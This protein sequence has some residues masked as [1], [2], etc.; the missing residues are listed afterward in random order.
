MMNYEDVLRLINASAGT[1]QRT[2]KEHTLRC[3]S[4]MGD[5]HLRIGKI[6]HVAGTNGKGSVSSYLESML[7]RAGNVTGKFT[8]PHLERINERIA[9]N[10]EPVSDEDFVRAYEAFER[11]AFKMTADGEPGFPYF[12]ILFLMGMHV[13]AEKC[14][15]VVILETGLGGRLDVTN[16][17]DMKA[18]TVITSISLDH[19]DILGP[20]VPI[21]AG[22]KAAIM[23]RGVPCVY[24]ALSLEASKV[25]EEYGAEIGAPVWPLGADD[26]VITEARNGE[27][28]FSTSFRYDGR[29][30]HRIHAAAPYQA[31]NAALS[32]LALKVLRESGAGEGLRLPTAQQASEGLMS[33]KWPARMEEILPRVFLDGAHNEDGVRRFSEA[34]RF[35]AGDERP[36]LLFAVMKRKD[37]GSMIKTLAG[38]IDWARVTVT[39]IDGEGDASAPELADLFRA[40]G[41][42]DVRV[43]PGFADAYREVL[44]DQGDGYVFIC[45][46]L[47]LAGLLRHIK[48]PG[49]FVK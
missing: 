30:D 34:V 20:T 38:E 22:E 41:I 32:L 37:Y 10:G 46:S 45:G 35:I 26:F 15:D 17:V 36:Q 44:A 12:D 42:R 16:K 31:E 4:L 47:Y 21:I 7:R 14:T 11:A 13:F 9:V 3:L 27:I 49:S 5:P 40:E 6:I 33:M 18:M 23:R 48:M 43:V 2:T 29:A 24:D 25:I 1:A 19:M 28:D 8:S 39:G